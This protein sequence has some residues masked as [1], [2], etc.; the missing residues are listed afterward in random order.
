[1]TLRRA[2]P[3]SQG[4][5][6]HALLKFVTD[7]NHKIHE[8]HSLMLLRHGVVIAEGWWRPY[9][10][11]RKHMLFSLTKSFT[12]TAFGLAVDEGLLTIEDKLL[13]FFPEQAPEKPGKNLKAMRLKHLLSMSTGH[14]ADTTERMVIGGG[15]DWVTAF[16]K[17]EVENPPGAPFV[18]NSGGS[19]M[20]AAVVQKVTGMK[21]SEYLK[22]RLFEPLGIKDVEW[23]TCPK[24]IEI[25]GWGLSL[26]T[27]EIAHFGQLYL[28]N[29]SWEGRQLIPSTWVAQATAKQ[30]SNGSDPKSDWA[31]GYGYHFWRCQHNAYRGDGAFGQY[32]VVMPEQDAVL[33][34]TSGVPELQ[35]PL[36][37]V[38]K[39]LLPAFSEHALLEDVTAHKKLLRKLDSLAL[40]GV[41]TGAASNMEADLAGNAYQMQ[42]N[43]ISVEQLAFDFT[44][45]ACIMGVTLAG[46]TD[47]IA[48]GRGEWA[49]G[50]TR[51]FSPNLT[52]MQVFAS[53][54]W[55][56]EDTL[57]LTLR[58]VETPFYFTLNCRFSGDELHAQ[59]TVNVAFGPAQYAEL[60]GKRIG[61]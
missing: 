13:S 43:E 25:G 59:P 56:A 48:C 55:I 19:Y 46:K 21:L 61:S 1:M 45:E 30:V 53:A 5:S 7:L 29:G 3:E 57:K 40:P 31:Q 4:V 28:Q 11:E 50:A 44:P 36:D 22:P 9:S 10:A 42:A 39:N 26:R 49:Q 47:H 20:L 58:Y 35:A 54:A 34:M 17:L 37:L 14:T 12:S 38:W 23:E 16:L 6:S 33:V 2:T 24:G 8:T 15:Q 27:E 60:V 41:E 51:L 32:C 52:S 18:Y